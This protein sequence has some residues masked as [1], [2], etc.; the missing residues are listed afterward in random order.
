MIKHHPDFELL[1]K[2]VSG[3]LPAALSVGIAIHADLCPQCKNTIAK[4]TEQVAQTKFE[5]FTESIPLKDDSYDEEEFDEMIDM[6]TASPAIDLVPKTTPSSVD[7]HHK[8]YTLP[9]VLAHIPQGK[10]TRFGKLS[11]SRLLLEEGDIHTSLLHIEPGGVVPKHTHKGFELTVLLDGSYSD[12]QGE[13][14]KGDFIL[15]DTHIHHQPK[16]DNGCLCYTVAND[17]LYFTEGINK[18]LNP[19]SG[20]I[21]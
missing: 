5:V 16:T 7:F 4:L 20:F 2:F 6:I 17:G 14:T 8:C 19:V 21:Y 11:R 15:L 13:Y 12:E 9:S 10:K 18:L 1:K 3:D